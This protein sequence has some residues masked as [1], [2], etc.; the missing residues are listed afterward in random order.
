MIV[1]SKTDLQSLLFK[2]VF[3]R[4]LLQF[5]IFL[6]LHSRTVSRQNRLRNYT[7]LKRFL[8]TVIESLNFLLHSLQRRFKTVLE[9]L[10]KPLLNVFFLV[11]TFPM[12]QY[13]GP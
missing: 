2:T 10:Q 12:E 8:K 7:L 11:V 13:F 3:K 5:S 1:V 9:Y 4:I 6:K